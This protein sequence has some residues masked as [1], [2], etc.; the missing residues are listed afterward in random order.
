[1]GKLPSGGGI[2]RF[3]LVLEKVLKMNLGK[4]SDWQF[5][6][7][8]QELRDCMLH[9]NGRIDLLKNEVNKVNI[10]RIVSSSKK[11]DIQSDRITLTDEFL[12]EVNLVLLRFIERVGDNSFEIENT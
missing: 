4:D 11:L 5:I 2:K 9:A 6:C 3:K 1:M 8:C 10:K 7:D 12:Q